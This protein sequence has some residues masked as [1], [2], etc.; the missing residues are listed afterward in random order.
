MT[1]QQAQAMLQKLGCTFVSQKDG[2]NW[3]RAADTSWV[4]LKSLG[5]G[6]VELRKLPAGSC[7]C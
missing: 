5:N 2:I 4:A 6:T 3:Y 7:G 1:P